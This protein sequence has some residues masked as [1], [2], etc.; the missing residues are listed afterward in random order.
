MARPETAQDVVELLRL[1]RLIGEPDLHR[2]A[3]QHADPL[4]PSEL[5]TRLSAAGHLTP[6][7]AEELASGR[8]QGFWLGA[9]KVLDR[10]GQGGMSQ[11]YLAEHAVLGCRVA[12]K[13]LSA[14]LRCDPESRR[15]FVREAR[16][17]ATIKHPNV[18]QVSAVDVD[19]DPPFLVMEYVDGVNLQA[20]VA[21]HGTFATEEAAAIGIEV[22]LGLAAAARAGL[23]HRDV[24]PANLLVDRRGGVK[25]LDLGIAHHSGE[26]ASLRYVGTDEILGTLDY[27]APEQV[28]NCS[29]VDVRA[30]LYSLGAT[31]YFLL[32]GYPPFPVQDARY[33]L[34]AKQCSDPPPVHRLRPDTAPGLSAVVQRLLAREPA[35]R[36]STAEAAGI[37][38]QPFA[39]PRRDFPAR[40]FRP[41]HHSTQND[42]VTTDRNASSLP[43]TERILKSGLR[44]V[45][46]HLLFPPTP[47]PETLG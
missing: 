46:T 7:Q 26:D 28:E 27:I 24:K 47:R 20:A 43:K 15:R 39:G 38:L 8:W 12:V 3:G 11:V 35:R 17:A 1:A 9:Y 41:Q 18:V 23:V 40:L 33:K 25:I 37:A 19:H 6:Y 14:G 45:P 13:V 2:V 32:A 36:Y 34:A 5:L 16:A 29:A 30:D 31:L 21:Q 10:L 4:T 44:I 22:A 42:A